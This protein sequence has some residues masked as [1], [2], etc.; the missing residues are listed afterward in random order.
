MGLDK[1]SD[2]A[3][4]R[5]MMSD[6]TT[7]AKFTD[8]VLS[9]LARTRD[10]REAVSVLLNSLRGGIRS[11]FSPESGRRWRGI[12]TLSNFETLLEQAGFDLVREY[13]AAGCVRRTYVEV[14]K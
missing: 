14:G 11:P 6:T 4:H 13:D 8:D 5:G 3:Y 9:V 1:S 12:G 7:Q 10:G 2:E